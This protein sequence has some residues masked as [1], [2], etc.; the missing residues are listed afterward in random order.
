[1][2]LICQLNR[3]L[4][5]V[6]MESR[7]VD[8]RRQRR[9]E[10]RLYIAN[11]SLLLIGLILGLAGSLYYA[12]LVN[13]ADTQTATAADL[14]A[15][16]KEDYIL[17]V[18]QAYAADGDWALA[19]ARLNQLNDPQLTETVV[20]QLEGYLRQGEPADVVRNLAELAKQLGAEGGALALFAPTPAVS[21][22][23]TV[24]GAAAVVTA[25]P[26]L[27]PTPTTDIEPSTTP[28]PT[29]TP[30]PSPTVPPTAV[31]NYRLLSQQ[32]LC[33]PYFD[34]PHIEVIVVDALLQEIPGVEI[35]ISWDEGEDHFFTGF[36]P[37]DG[38]GYADFTMEEGVSYSVSIVEGS[39]PVGGLSAEPCPNGSGWQG[40]LLRFQNT[41]LV[42]EEEQEGDEG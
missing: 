10:N 4:R 34:E 26:T 19:V 15:D 12:W 42:Q 7:Q 22:T 30:M 35:M 1:M 39:L 27:L 40:W 33:Q 14:H 3:P 21:A 32:Q 20:Q 23:P 2:T 9:R 25:T 38:P 36:K 29:N 8:R 18:S 5:G 11:A 24:E 13:P 17:M 41:A 6:P 37:L 31:P 16:Y 28:L